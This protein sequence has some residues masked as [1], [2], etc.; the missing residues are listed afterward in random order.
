MSRA[1]VCASFFSSVYESCFSVCESQSQCVKIL[2][3]RVNFL[4][5]LL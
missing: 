4:K 2:L 3:V 5:F 1:I